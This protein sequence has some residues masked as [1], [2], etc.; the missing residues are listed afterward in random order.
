MTES[1]T[2]FE[3]IRDAFIDQWGA[4]GGAWGINRTMAQIHALLMVSA[5]PLCCDAVMHELS[6]SRGNANTNLRE[7]VNWGLV[8]TV[9]VRGSRKDFFEA[10]KD[11]W[12]I[13]CAISR[14]RKRREID[15]ALAVLESCRSR[16]T[17][18]GHPEAAEFTRMITDLTEFLSLTSQVMESVSRT[19]RGVVM[20]AALKLLGRR[21][22]SSH[23][24][25]TTAEAD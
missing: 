16:A 2:S 5:E 18:S 1:E 10:E 15:P 19:D 3:E 21:A 4:M 11:V 14:E 9:T 25:G 7:L 24:P 12:K 17:E 23:K 22:G 20:P 13:F 6:I 8:R